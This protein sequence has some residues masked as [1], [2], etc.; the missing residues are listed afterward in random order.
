MGYTHTPE[1]FVFTGVSTPDCRGGI[2]PSWPGG[3]T[4]DSPYVICLPQ[5][6]TPTANPDIPIGFP[7]GIDGIM[8]YPADDHRY[9][10]DECKYACAFDQRCLGFEFVPDVDSALGDCNLIDDIPL[11]VSLM[12]TATIDDASPPTADQESGVGDLYSTMGLDE[13]NPTAGLCYALK[14]DYCNPYF[15]EHELTDVMLNCYCPNNRKGFYT[16]KVVRTEAAS[17]YCGTEPDDMPVTKR[18]RNAQANRMF[19]L[20]ENWCLF[21]TETP[22]TE[23]WYH[24]PWNECWREQYAGVGTHRSYCFRVI[25]DPM[26]IEQFFID[27]RADR[28][29]TTDSE[30]MPWTNTP[31]QSPVSETEYPVNIRMY[32][33]GEEESCDDACEQRDM[34][35]DGNFL[36]T[37][38]N[39][40][41]AESS[42]NELFVQAAFQA[43]GYSCSGASVGGKEGWALPGMLASQSLCITRNE[44]TTKTPCN[45][46]IGVGYRRLCACTDVDGTTS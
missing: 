11:E 25:R 8:T 7:M 28:M 10:I 26:T 14:D 20:C 38:T 45:L 37:M 6:N 18:I 29:C 44:T 23:S 36:E 3:Q 21:N 9:S 40:Y 12:P 24:D 15:H 43:S 41:A 31:T 27:T 46:A 33:A 4:C 32:L 42:A 19:H 5:E 39:E 22:R 35:C 1:D 34:R 17:R 2:S 13:T 30:G 16:K